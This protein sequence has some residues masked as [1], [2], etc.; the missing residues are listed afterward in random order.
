MHAHRLLMPNI[1]LLGN[2][3]MGS[4][5]RLTKKNVELPAT[6]HTWLLHINLQESY[7][8]CVTGS[9]QSSGRWQAHQACVP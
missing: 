7:H 8:S 6:L 1:S 2:N 9:M 3:A 5:I 4:S